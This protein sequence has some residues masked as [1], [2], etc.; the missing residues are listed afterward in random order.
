MD[1]DGSLDT[2]TLFA[3]YAGKRPSTSPIKDNAMTEKNEARYTEDDLLYSSA[4][5]QSAPIQ[6]RCWLPRRT[7]RRRLGS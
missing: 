6:C 2:F 4:R 5:P 1:V 3:P 7:Y